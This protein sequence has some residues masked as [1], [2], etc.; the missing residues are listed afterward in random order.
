MIWTDEESTPCMRSI[1]P[2]VVVCN[3]AGIE[4]EL[5][6]EATLLIVQRFVL[7]NHNSMCESERLNVREVAR[8]LVRLRRF[9]NSTSCLML[10]L[11]EVHESSVGSFALLVNS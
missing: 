7:S 11:K 2:D 8:N 5:P 3:P 4:T 1:P 9:G 10:R 6:G